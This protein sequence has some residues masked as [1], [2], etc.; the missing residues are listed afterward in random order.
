MSKPTPDTTWINTTPRHIK[1]REAIK[2]M[3]SCLATLDK[4]EFRDGKDIWRSMLFLFGHIYSEKLI[5]IAIAK[6]QFWKLLL[7][8]LR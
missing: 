8:G 5:I 2:E 3:L 1:D 7:G 4:H 6:S